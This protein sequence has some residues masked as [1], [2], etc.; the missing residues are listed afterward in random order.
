MARKKKTEQQ[1][2]QSSP[3]AELAFVPVSEVV[4]MKDMEQAPKPSVEP[5]I[6][7]LEQVALANA[8]RLSPTYKAHHLSS[9]KA[10]CK[11]RGLPE[12]GSEEQMLDVL[13]SY[14]YKF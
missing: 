9:L 1:Q 11:N 4:E 7:S 5:V 3:T 14:G 10:F 13:R 8:A 2:E 6:L 12:S